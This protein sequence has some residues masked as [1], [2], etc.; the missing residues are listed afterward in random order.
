MTDIIWVATRYDVPFGV[1]ITP[2]A[3]VDMARREGL[4]RCNVEPADAELIRPGR[5]RSWSSEVA[6]LREVFALA[7]RG[8]D[9]HGKDLS[10]EDDEDLAAYIDGIEDEIDRLERP[11]LSLH[12]RLRAPPRV[13]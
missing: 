7:C 11:P 3:A 9:A 10:I 2:E 5:A 4:S 13:E 1:G 12:L 8:K 6:F